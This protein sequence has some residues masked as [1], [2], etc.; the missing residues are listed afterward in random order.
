M[1]RC[2]V[3]KKASWAKM[4]SEFSLSESPSRWSVDPPG[5]D[6]Q[7]N[8][9]LSHPRGHKHERQ[10]NNKSA[11]LRSSCPD[12]SMVDLDRIHRNHYRCRERLSW[13]D[14]D[15][16]KE[17]W[18]AKCHRYIHEKGDV[19]T[20]CHPKI[21]KGLWNFFQD[22]RSFLSPA[23]CGI[24]KSMQKVWSLQIVRMGVE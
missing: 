6:K 4:E 7:S 24:E 11:S 17:S 10:H 18:R 1:G 20:S 23:V 5:E 21:K 2:A 12:K 13:S 15:T 22:F 19:E 16:E 3:Q 8:C 9:R 14:S